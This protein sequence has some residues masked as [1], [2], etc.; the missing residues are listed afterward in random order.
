[1]KKIIAV[2]GFV[3]TLSCLPASSWASGDTNTVGGV[4]FFTQQQQLAAAIQANTSRSFNLVDGVM[5]YMMMARPSDRGLQFKTPTVSTAVSGTSFEDDSL[6][7]LGG[8]EVGGE[9]G[10][11]V[12]IYDGLIAGLVYQHSFR[13]ATGSFATGERRD[14]D[15]ISFYLAKRFFDIFN[16]GL[17]YNFASSEHRLTGG[18]T[19]NLDSDGHGFAGF[20]GISDR[21]VFWSK[22]TKWNWATTTSF[23]YVRD[24]YSVSSNTDTDTGRFTWGGNLGYDVTKYFT[25]SGAFNYHNFVIMDSFNGIPGRD[26]DY[27]TLGPRLQFYP[28]DNVTVSLDFE[29]MQGYADYSSYTLRLGASVV[30]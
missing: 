15:G 13:D 5:W 4:D 26:D 16:T 8:W 11:D 1:M 27:W 6:G 12:D 25:L 30:F 21:K 3:L 28:L 20:A 24:D 9:L 29:S 18:T 14:S 2:S 17:A 22:S 7:G 10:L 23:A 19:A